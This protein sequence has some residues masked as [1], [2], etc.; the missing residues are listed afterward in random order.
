MLMLMLMLTSMNNLASVL[1][2]QGKYEEAELWWA[3]QKGLLL[4]RKDVDPNF[5][6]SGKFD[7]PEFD[8]A[9][10][11]AVT[12]PEFDLQELPAPPDL[13][14]I[15]WPEFDAPELLAITARV[16][17]HRTERGLR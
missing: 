1:H 8:P 11:P 9:E 13:S 16:T 2:S 5:L 17:R 12:W 4:K 15:T 7:L 3:A 14:A 6:D 10:L